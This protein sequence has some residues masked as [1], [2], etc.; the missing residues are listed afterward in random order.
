MILYDL[1]LPMP[2]G[3]PRPVWKAPDGHLRPVPWTQR[4]GAWGKVDE[5]HGRWYAAQEEGL[6][7]IC[8][9]VVEEGVVIFCEDEWARFIYFAPLCDQ[10]PKP[11]LVTQHD[12]KRD[13]VADHGPL[14]ER[15]CALMTRS[16]CKTI[17]DLLAAGTVKFKPYKK[18]A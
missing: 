7:L 8:G 3:L 2:S 16:H 1:S 6:C 15:P 5:T 13:W 11:E 18:E 10:R 14:H 17:R 12:L 4:D 9:E